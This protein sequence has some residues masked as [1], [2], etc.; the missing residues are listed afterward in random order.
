MALLGT[1]RKRQETR[2]PQDA[3][4]L[5][6]V[7]V[8]DLEGGD[9]RMGELWSERPAALVFIR[10]YGCT[11]CRIYVS[12]LNRERERFEEAGVDLKVVG[13]GRPE[14]AARFRE[15]QGLDL[16]LYADEQRLSYK[17]G[18]MKKATL[19]ELVGPGVLAKGIQGAAKERVVQGRFIGHP[20]QLG[21]VLVV[22]PD[23]SIAYSHLSEDAGDNPPVDEVLEAARA[24]SA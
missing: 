8:K 7:T 11:H 10:H 2:P 12:R 21:G 19:G 24:A 14:Q 15:K 18:G 9:V 6:G 22:R 5:A 1:E 4:E 17:A 3:S 13:Q 20:A 16:D 23:G